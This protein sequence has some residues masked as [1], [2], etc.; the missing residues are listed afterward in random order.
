MGESFLTVEGLSGVPRI[1]STISTLL[2]RVTDQN[3]TLASTRRQ[4][5]PSPPPPRYAVAFYALE[6]PEITIRCYLDRIFQ[7]AHCSPSC[8]VVAYI[9]LDRFLNFHPSIAID[10]FSV[11]RF[12]ITAVLTSVKFMEDRCYNN[13]YFARVGGISLD[14]MNYLEVD[15]LFGLRFNL[16]VTPVIFSSYCSFLDKEMNLST[17]T[18]P[19]RL[20]CFPSE[21]ESSS[22]CKQQQ[23]IV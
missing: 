3:D 4:V 23:L 6:K 14:E 17:P 9:Y 11:H 15:F 13:A 22:S 18:I 20:H 16:N 5:P 21:E 19:P 1:V 2:Q 8:Y 12:L 7:F 10:S